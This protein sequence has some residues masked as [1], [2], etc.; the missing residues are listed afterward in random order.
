MDDLRKQVKSLLQDAH[1]E[2]V[3]LRAEHPQRP[4]LVE[5]L[6]KSLTNVSSA[7]SIIVDE[8]EKIKAK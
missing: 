2:I 6:D 7:I 5:Q 1:Y 3:K 4:N 8:I